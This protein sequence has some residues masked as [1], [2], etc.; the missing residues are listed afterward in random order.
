[1]EPASLTQWVLE[2][3]YSIRLMAKLAV[4]SIVSTLG[5][6]AGTIP[7]VSIPSAAPRKMFETSIASPYQDLSATAVGDRI[8]A[9]IGSMGP[10]TGCKSSAGTHLASDAATPEDQLANCVSDAPEGATG[11]T[12]LGVHYLW[13]VVVQIEES[14]TTGGVSI[15]SDSVGALFALSLS[16]NDTSLNI[17]AGVSPGLLPGPR[18]GGIEG[19]NIR[20]WGHL[21]MLPSWSDFGSAVLCADGSTVNGFDLDSNISPCPVGVAPAALCLGGGDS[22]AVIGGTPGGAIEG[23]LDFIMF[24]PATPAAPSPAA[25]CR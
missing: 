11:I 19:N 6:C 17:G 1:M 18:A 16:K 20:N 10:A 4:A 9:D 23:G 3:V 12:S 15:S 7:S 13:N 14:Y 8:D 24:D 5:A 2:V 22:G 21:A 25:A